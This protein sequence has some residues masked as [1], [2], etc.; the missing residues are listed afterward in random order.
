MNILLH[1]YKLI[2]T[3]HNIQIQILTKLKLTTLQMSPSKKKALEYMFSW[4]K[5]K[6]TELMF[7]QECD[8]SDKAS[9]LGLER[10]HTHLYQCLYQPFLWQPIHAYKSAKR[11]MNIVYK[12][13]GIVKQEKQWDQKIPYILDDWQSKPQTCHD[14]K[15]QCCNN[16]KAQGPWKQ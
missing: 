15:Y 13:G 8:P 14:I 6:T 7:L 9:F 12:E 3:L 16:K 2:Y 1:K 5:K 10:K 4:F 11:W